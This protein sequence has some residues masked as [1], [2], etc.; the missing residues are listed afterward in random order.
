MAYLL[1]ERLAGHEVAQ[2]WRVVSAGTKAMVGSRMC[3]AAARTIES[4]ASGHTF[5]REHRSQQLTETMVRSAALVLVASKYERI[6]VTGLSPEARAKTFTMLEG[7]RLAGLA[8]DRGVV[9][10]PQQEPGRLEPLRATLHQHRGQLPDGDP[11][12]TPWQRWVSRLR[13][14]DPLEIQDVHRGE[15]W[16][17]APV[18][19]AL[20][21]ASDTFVGSVARLNG[22]SA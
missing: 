17:H 4:S 5:V 7:A 12:R 11:S 15:V 20:D 21:W 16:S 9:V 13:H 19:G 10:W 3:R 14:H 6:A 1:E 18:V 22:G 8:A 2:T